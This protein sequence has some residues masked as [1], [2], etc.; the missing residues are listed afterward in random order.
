MLG[1]KH[2]LAPQALMDFLQARIK[3]FT[4]RT[5]AIRADI[6]ALLESNE[7]IEQ[8]LENPSNH[9]VLGRL[10]SE[11]ESELEGLQCCLELCRLDREIWRSALADKDYTGD[12][13]DS[14]SEEE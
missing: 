8:V 10:L 1:A 9:K 7:W 4:A 13:I 5:M 12:E 2:N 14:Y 11:R 6:E 3:T